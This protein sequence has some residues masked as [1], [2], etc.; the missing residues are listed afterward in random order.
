MN[1]SDWILRLWH[2]IDKSASQSLLVGRERRLWD[3]TRVD[4]LTLDWAIEVDWAPKWAEGIGQ[5]LWYATVTGKKPGVC[6]LC[7]DMKKDKDHIYRCHTLCVKYDIMLWL[8]DT[9]NSIG[10]D[11]LG[12]RI[13]I[14]G[15][16]D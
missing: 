15:R 14:T 4:I 1:E 11:Q 16:V 9:K 12:Q 7:K 5:A 13:P 8:V 2:Q 3:N 10:I 6:L